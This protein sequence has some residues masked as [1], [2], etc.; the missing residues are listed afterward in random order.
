MPFLPQN[1]NR[2]FWDIDPKN[3]TKKH[4]KQ[5]IARLLDFGN[6]EAIAWCKEQF[7]EKEITECLKTSRVLSKKSAN[8]WA[9]KF[10]IPKNQVLCLQPS[11]R[12]KHRKL[13][14]Y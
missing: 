3:L 13:W 10:D 9:I 2:Y 1:L 8:F 5:I 6:T 14:N 4:K 11:F 7:S 12:N